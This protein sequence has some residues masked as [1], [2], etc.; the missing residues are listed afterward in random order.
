[1]KATSL[2]L[3]FLTM[4][5]SGFGQTAAQRFGA[6]RESMQGREYTKAVD[7]LKAIEDQYP[8]SFRSNDLDYLAARLSQRNGNTGEAAAYF[9]KVRSRNSI[10]REY[11]TWHLSTI[12]REGGNLVGERILLLDLLADRPGSLLADAAQK[13]LAESYFVSKDFDSAIR[14]LENFAGSGQRPRELEPLYAKSLL[15]KNEK[16]A[17][18]QKFESIVSTSANPAQPDDFALEA[19]KAIDLIEVG[20]ERFGKEVARLSDYE[21]LKRASIYQFNRDFSDARLHFLAIVNNH[22]A[23]G[24][25]PDAL[26]QIG[27]GYTQISDFV[28]AVKWY[29]RVGEQ[30]PE[31]PVNKDALLQLASAYSRLGRHREAVARY[32]LYIRNYPNDE[33]LDR[34][35]LNIVDVLR[36]AGEATEAAN[37]ADRAA[38]VFKGKA[39]E[40]QAIFTKAR[41]RIA[42]TEWIEALADL[43]RLLTLKDLGGAGIPGG[44]T[45]T[46]V[47]FLR[48]LVLEEL[49][50]YSEAID[51]Y[52]DIP[53][54]RNEYYGWRA[55]VRLRAMTNIPEAK[56]FTDGKILS[57]TSSTVQ[58][59]EDRKKILHDTIRL[60][61]DDN[62]RA[63]ALE[64]LK[65]VYAQ[66]PAYQLP[67]LPKLP[68]I[69]RQELRIAAASADRS[70]KALG[71][72]LAF[73][74]LFDEAAPEYEAAMRGLSVEGK[75]LSADVEF[76][77]A[78]MYLKGDRADRVAT[79]I[80]PL[81]RSLPTD[82]QV[83]LLPRDLTAMLYPIPY[84]EA[85]LKH[86]PGRGVDPR[87]LLSIM[88][89]ESRFRPNVKSIA[90]ARG[91]MQFIPDTSNKI[92]GELGRER[93]D[94]NE[95]YYPPTA[96]LFGSQYVA[97]LFK[98]F[99]NLPD[100][101]AASYNGGED[102]MKR[103]LGRSK[104]DYAGRYVPEIGFA[105]SKDYV[106]RVMANYRMYQLLYDENLNRK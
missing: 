54:G 4:M 102:N 41:I 45:R 1:M 23:S 12:A 37:R 25:E 11:A 26:Y 83:E 94:Q 96:I 33:K 76:T 30:H 8:S 79:F 29:E 84:R 48:G 89:Q 68:D 71:E 63:K 59:L 67:S 86:A 17:A 85:L 65:T 53:D 49:R 7:E 34:A 77:I 10:V 92:A 87:L 46:E 38:E 20:S 2:I 57:R 24:L 15:F 103:W 64:E 22:S 72:E 14:S 52:L 95:L 31:H 66:L 74:G 75:K 93:F 104:S 9:Q 81:V 80:E 3:V 27:R 13:R 47:T 18:R 101:I 58:S 91:L 60:I 106:W 39:A 98:L 61:S 6:V 56:L 69:G 73:L 5:T 82:F 99:P 43:D 40:G 36:D 51:V 19:V 44:T 42:Q 90:A 21:H 55:S 100:A 50:R 88:R 78:S 32:E 97:N 62:L 16:E 70:N 28:D 105:Q 35:Y